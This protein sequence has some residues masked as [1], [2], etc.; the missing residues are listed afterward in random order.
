MRRRTHIAGIC[1]ISIAVAVL[2]GCDLF[3]PVGPV[4]VTVIPESGAINTQVTISGSGFGASQGGSSVTLG[5]IPALVDSW[6]DASIIVR[7][8]VIPTPQGSPVAT[9][10]IVT[11]N[12]EAVGIS[13]F[14]VL[15]GILY[16]AE[17]GEHFVICHMNPDGTN[18]TDLT[19]ILGM[20]MFPVWSPD[21]TK[22]AFMN[23][24]GENL[25]IHVVDADGSNKRRLTYDPAWDLFP[26]WSPDG[27]R[28][29][30]QTNRDGNME[31]Y[32]MNADGT[33]QT[34]LTGYSKLDA[35]PSWSPDGTKILYYSLRTASLHIE[36]IEP[37][38][39]LDTLEIMAMDADGTDAVN[40]SRNTATDQLPL[41][42]PDG[43]NIA[44]QSDRDGVGEIFVM[45]SDGSNQRNITDN[46][47]ADGWPCW[48]PEGTRMAFVSSRD[49][50]MEIYVVNADGS[51]LTKLT[52][53]S[54]WDGGP[55][56]SSDGT[57]IAFET[58][59]DGDYR[60]YV[61]NADGTDPTRLT[62]E[63]SSYPVWL[64]SRWIVVR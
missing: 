42:S 60:V 54:A 56:W 24:S 15:R 2:A 1:L 29:L 33:G 14:T 52:N 62:N 40:L 18:K 58:N 16:V 12:G 48:S 11:V 47:A 28:I 20:A 45:N 5:G 63:K 50:D 32:I 31:I 26:T 10:V 23:R 57:Q 21:G 53:N 25:D 44:F 39:V 7:V 34:N 38:S 4:S 36:E 43:T 35:W 27:Q 59:R 41:W 13:T 51:G 8:P 37:S 9:D 55:T 22:I 64:T 61:M 17:R 3:A 49:G 6:T 46:P 30:F 19:N